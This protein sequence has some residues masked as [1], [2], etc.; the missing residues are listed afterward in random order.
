MIQFALK[1]GFLILLVLITVACTEQ[2]KEENRLRLFYFQ[3]AA[4]WTEALPLG[5]GFLGAMVY[6]GVEKEHIQFNEETLW[7][8]EPHDYAHK[9]ASNYLEEIR[10]LLFDGK[11]E[12]AR[13]LA[14]EEFLSIPVRQMAYQPF[15]DLYIEFPGHEFYTDYIRELNLA[16]AVCKTSYRVDNEEYRREVIASH[17]HQCIVI[18]LQS[19]R[20]HSLNCI[21]SFNAE[22]NYWP[23]ELLNLPEC[24]GPFFRLIEECAIT[25][26]SI[27]REH[28]ACEGWVLHHNTDIW[29]GAAPI[30]SAPYGVWPTGAAWVCSHLWEHYLFTQDVTFLRERA[31]P[32]MKEAA[33]FYSQFLVKDPQTGWLISTP[34]NSPENGGLV[35]G[36]TMDHQLIRSLFKYCIKSPKFLKQRMTLPGS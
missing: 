32:L 35:A 14:A 15:G 11:N 5:N 1:R 3:P 6:G 23:A 27:A 21:V 22:M 8:G 12:E 10:Q 36:P 29:R 2:N 4:E 9:G 31:Y 13:E 28:Y 24:H 30:N 26:Q 25:G 18:K 16:N 19:E 34:S 20:K 17:P 33:R 7:T